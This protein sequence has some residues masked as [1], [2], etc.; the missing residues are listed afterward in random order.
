[1]VD[2]KLEDIYVINPAAKLRND[3]K[4]VIATLL[5]DNNNVDGV[6]SNELFSICELTA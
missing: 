2:N 4:Y 6:C 3:G 1:M 5:D